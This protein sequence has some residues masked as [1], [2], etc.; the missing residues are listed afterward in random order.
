MSGAGEWAGRAPWRERGKKHS[1]AVGRIKC[2]GQAAVEALGRDTGGP[3]GPA[4]STTGYRFPGYALSMDER[5][6]ALCIRVS[7]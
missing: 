2:P 1:E 3:A 5:Q 4:T 7:F 6:G